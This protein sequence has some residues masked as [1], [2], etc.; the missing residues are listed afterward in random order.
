MW[1]VIYKPNHDYEYNVI[2]G[3][4]KD[5]KFIATMLGCEMSKGFNTEQEAERWYYGNKKS[6]E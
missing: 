2:G 3:K 6:L 1:Y 4:K 5:I